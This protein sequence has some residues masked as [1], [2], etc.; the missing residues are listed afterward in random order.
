MTKVDARLDNLVVLIPAR[1]GSK[2]IENKNLCLVGSS[3]LLDRAIDCAISLTAKCN[4][5]SPLM[6]I[7]YLKSL[8]PGLWYHWK[9]PQKLPLTQPQQ[10]PCLK[11][12]AQN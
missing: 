10:T 1:G 4:I 8:K 11:N 7:R 2:G 6:I 5:L 12:S 9:G 3:T